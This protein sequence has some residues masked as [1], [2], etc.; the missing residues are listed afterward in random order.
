[1]HI[2]IDIFT[3]IE[4]GHILASL[5]DENSDGQQAITITDGDLDLE[6]NELT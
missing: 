4:F 5:I 2:S 3:E 1:M 6:H